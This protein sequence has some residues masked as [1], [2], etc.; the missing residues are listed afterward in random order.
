MGVGVHF[1]G[2]A[3]LLLCLP[4]KAAAIW[5]VFL[6]VVCEAFAFAILG[7]LSESVMSAAIPARERA[8]ANSLITAM[9]LLI[10]IPVGWIA[11][12]LSQHNRMLPLAMNL[13]LLLAEAMMVVLITNREKKKQK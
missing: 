10:S 9:I 1:L 11:G 5:A 2:L 13:C 7:P 8:R 3:V 6:S 4:I 12:Q